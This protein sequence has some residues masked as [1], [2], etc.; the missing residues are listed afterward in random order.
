MKQ[1]HYFKR[2]LSALLL[3]MASTLSWAY[4]FEAENADG[5]W[6]YYNLINNKTEAEVTYYSSS[7]SS[8]SSKYSGDIVIPSTVVYDGKTLSVTS[9]GASAF[10]NCSSLTSVTIPEGVTSIGHY[11]FDGCI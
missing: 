10:R 6:I 9:I 2:M 3:L 4:D 1:N 8:N 11:T 7:S 5:K